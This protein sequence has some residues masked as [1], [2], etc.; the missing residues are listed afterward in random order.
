MTS[1]TLNYIH[2][3]MCS[4]CWA[5]RPVHDNLKASLPAKVKWKN[6]LGGLAPDTKLP[7]PVETREM[8]RSHWRTI[9]QRLGTQFNFEFWDRK[10]QR[11]STYPSCRAVLVAAEH[12]RED[13]MIDAIQR[14]Y[15]LRALNP[16]NDETLIQ[17]AGE[18]GLNTATFSRQLA[19]VDTHH[20][21]LAEI[22][23]V[24]AMGVSSFPSLV[25]E[26]GEQMFRIPHD[27][28]DAGSSLVAI[29]DLM[30]SPGADG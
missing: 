26:H 20:A 4:W 22:T 6:L 11:R 15:Y 5:Y 18:I 17:L 29:N 21:L 28:Q 16:S 25:L 10:D 14:A 1:S 8:I 13:E 7:M 3:P 19:S 30:Q 27:Y 12:G 2:D 24:R 23:K 9:Q